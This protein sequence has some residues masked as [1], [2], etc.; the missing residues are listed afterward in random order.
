MIE[1]LG[2]ALNARGNVVSDANKMTSL[3]GVFTAGD[4][5]AASHWWSGQSMKDARQPKGCIV[6]NGMKKIYSLH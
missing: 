3:P 1:E 6:I 5:T 4:I 2:V